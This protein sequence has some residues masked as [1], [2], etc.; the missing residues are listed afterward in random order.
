MCGVTGILTTAGT[1]RTAL[2][3]I[4]R[5]M[6]EPLAHRGPDDS[7]IWVDGAAG[8]ALAHRRLSILDLSPAGHQ[9]ML[10][11]SRRFAIVFNGEIYNHLELRRELD[12]N[13]TSDRPELPMVAERTW[14]GRSDTET[15]L[16]AFETWGV[17]KTLQKAIGMFAFG[18]WD[19]EASVL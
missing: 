15:L 19:C 13:L 3:T 4:V 6:S 7:G 17:E 8:V 5:R 1:D 10:S 14:R 16:A 2:D 9:P 12:G 18:L 11:A